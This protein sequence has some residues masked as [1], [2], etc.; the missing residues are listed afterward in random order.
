M[1]EQEIYDD[2]ARH[3]LSFI[4]AIHRLENIGYLPEDAED[5]VSE[6]ANGLEADASEKQ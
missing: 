3:G 2:F 1:T 4:D 6:W 5:M